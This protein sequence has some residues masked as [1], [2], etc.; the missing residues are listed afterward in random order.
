MEQ[1]KMV[2]AIHPSVYQLFYHNV[3]NISVKKEK[4]L[5]KLGS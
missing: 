1:A 2:S 5:K 3:F 4:T